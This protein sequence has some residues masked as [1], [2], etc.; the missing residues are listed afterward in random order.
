MLKRIVKAVYKAMVLV[1]VVL[2]VFVGVVAYFI[3]SIFNKK[4]LIEM[5]RN[6]EAQEKSSNGMT[7]YVI[8]KEGMCFCV[9]ERYLQNVDIKIDKIKILKKYCNGILI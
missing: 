9:H 5:D 1:M 8:E 4:S 7:Y 2:S 6:K 3:S